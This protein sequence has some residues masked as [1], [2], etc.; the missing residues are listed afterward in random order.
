MLNKFLNCIRDHTMLVKGDKVLVGL[1]GGADSVCLLLSLL[2]IKDEYELQI[3]AIH[4]NHQLRG[5]ESDS[6]ELFCIGLCERLGVPLITQKLDV[7]AYS[8]KTGKSTE[9]AARDLRYAAFREH[10]HGGKIA[11]AHSLSDTAETILLNLTRGTALKGL[12]GIPPVRDNIIRPL[13]SSSREEIESYLKEKSQSFVIDKTNLSEDYTRNKIR[14]GIMPKFK[15]IN[16]NLLGSIQKTVQSLTADNNYLDIVTQKVYNDCKIKG[17]SLDACL[18][19]AEHTA[20]RRRCIAMFLKK[21]GLSQSF[22]KIISIENILGSGGKINIEKNVYIAVKMGILSIVE[23]SPKYPDVQTEIQLGD[24]LFF[25][26]N[27]NIQLLPYEQF[28]HDQIVNKK[29][30]INIADYDKIQGKVVLRNRRS[31]D[32]IQLINRN[33]ESSVKKLFNAQIPLGE[34]SRLAFLADE[35]GVIF[36]EGFGISDRVKPDDR[37]E[38]ALIIVMDWSVKD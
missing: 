34:R 38:R 35:A 1:S 11:T 2:E 18:L 13:I 33:F 19:A 21:N 26:K 22:D 23:D 15:E 4:L 10:S 20:V 31:G 25:D 29:F 24:N 8:D 5:K 27:V 32:K 7:A 16:P 6:D 12:C 14:L 9:E 37:T 3:S 30:A 28:N 36:I 17:D